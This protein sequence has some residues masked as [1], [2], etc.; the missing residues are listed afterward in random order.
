[1]G[2]VEAHLGSHPAVRECV[3]VAHQGAVA[4]KRL[5]AY[6]VCEE[7]SELSEEE[8]RD[9]LMERAPEYMLPSK[10][11]WLERMPLTA[12]GKVDRRALPAPGVASAEGQY[13]EPEGETERKLAQIWADVLKVE[14][15][16]RQDNFFEL[17]GHSL[18]AVRLIQQ[19]RREGLQCEVRTLYTEPTLAEF[20]AAI[21][22]EDVEVAL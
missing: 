2:E 9:Y 19:M 3:V 1:L 11:V 13:E 16:G 4:E 17:G 15:V 22:D 18:L 14:R 20:A 7:G 8:L 10:Y 6:L 5:V 12:N 21:E